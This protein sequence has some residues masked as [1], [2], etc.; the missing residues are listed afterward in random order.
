MRCECAIRSEESLGQMTRQPEAQKVIA[1]SSDVAGTAE[2]AATNSADGSVSPFP[3]CVEESAQLMSSLEHEADGL[4]KTSRPVALLT[5][6]IPIWLTGVVL[7]FSY[8]FG[9]MALVKNLVVAAAASIPAGRFIIWAGDA[10]GFSA[11]QFAFVIFYLDI[12]WAVVLTW[13]AGFLF[14][15]PSVGPRLKGA[16]QE[17]TL[18]L[19]RNRWMKRLTVLSVL[20]F[21][22]LPVSSTGSIGG[23]LL[24]RLLGLT[25]PAT[26]SIVVL[27][28][29]LGCAVMLA[30]AEALRPWF[31]QGGFAVRY[32]GLAVIVLFFFVLS[33]RYRRSLEVD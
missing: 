23:S 26:L 13:H 17:G 18:L 30:G 8:V 28:S 5:L 16:V 11:L 24:G 31:E 29:I 19:K 6:T 14:H 21:V 12:I 33:R 10:G 27:G 20:L 4:W 32:G 3:T 9:G 22:M 1:Q 7:V 15:V 25:R 2:F